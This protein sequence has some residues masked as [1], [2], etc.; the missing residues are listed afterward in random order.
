MF[1]NLKFSNDD[2][3]PDVEQIENWAEGYFYSVFNILN[4]FLCTVDIKEATD[5]MDDIPFEHLV[6][7][8]L[9]NEDE[10]V[11]KI[12]TARIKELAKDE[13][14]VMKAYCEL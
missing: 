2:G 13:I 7:E 8:Q 6:R 1:Q 10:Q 4:G 12:A 5:R 11:I 3:S 14:E 9:E